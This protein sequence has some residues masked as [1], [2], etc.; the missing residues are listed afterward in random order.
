MTRPKPKAGRVPKPVKGFR[1]Y[2]IM[3]SV[4]PHCGG[5][6]RVKSEWYTCGDANHVE[7]KSVTPIGGR[8]K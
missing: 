1:Y 6:G 8:R 4:C 5:T 2:Y 7:T 3:V